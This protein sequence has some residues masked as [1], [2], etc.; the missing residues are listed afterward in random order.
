MRNLDRPSSKRN[1]TGLIKA[2]RATFSTVFS[3][4]ARYLLNCFFW[5][6]ALPSQLLFLALHA[7]FSTAF[8]GAA[9]HLLNCFF[10]RCALPSQLLSLALRA[11]L[12]NCFFWRCAPA[13]STTFSVAARRPFQLLLMTG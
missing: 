4:A 9:R 2:L 13:F 1:P 11:G 7:T 3:G 8:S 5:R 12:F 10:W 6:C